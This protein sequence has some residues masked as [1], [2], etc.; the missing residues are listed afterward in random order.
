MIGQCLWLNS[1]ISTFR[2]YFRCYKIG[3]TKKTYQQVNRL[4]GWL[5]RIASCK[6]KIVMERKSSLSRISPTGACPPTPS[7]CFD[8]HRLIL[9][10]SCSFCPFCP[11]CSPHVDTIWE[12]LLSN[13][14]QMLNSRCLKIIFDR[15]N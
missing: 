12:T 10:F 4:W 8:P 7:V 3:R 1:W 15:L 5:R 14:K 13:P 6:D 11:N 2:F 9:L